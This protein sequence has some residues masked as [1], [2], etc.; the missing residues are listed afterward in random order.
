MHPMVSAPSFVEGGL[1]GLWTMQRIGGVL[2]SD[3]TY[4]TTQKV[5]CQERRKKIPGERS[6]G[7]HGRAHGDWR[8]STKEKEILAR[9]AVLMMERE[10]EVLEKW[11]VGGKVSM[12]ERTN[13]W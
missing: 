4:R 7:K 13:V 11:R 8:A 6:M 10:V 12:D 2:G 5:A 3:G 1:D 9:A